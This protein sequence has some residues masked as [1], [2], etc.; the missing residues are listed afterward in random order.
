[1]SL[2][3]QRQYLKDNL[4]IVLIT[5]NRKNKLKNMVNGIFEENSPIKDCSITFLDNHSDDGT[6]EY[7]Q[8]LANK[9][10]N[11]IHIRHKYNIGGNA[12]IVRAM[13][14]VDTNKKYFW[15]LCD[16]DMLDWTHW[17]YH[18]T[19]LEEE[20]NDIIE[21]FYNF[22]V[23]TGSVYEEQI[24]SFTINATFVP[25]CI[26]KTRWL[27]EKNIFLNAYVNIHAMFP[28]AALFMHIVNNKGKI[29]RC[30]V[31][32]QI[33]YMLPYPNYKEDYHRGVNTT[34]KLHPH[35]QTINWQVGFS[36]S[37]GML[38]N[39]IIKK[40][41]VEYMYSF[42]GRTLEQFYSWY[43]PYALEYQQWY[44]LAN[45]YTS[46][47]EVQKNKI[48]ELL[49]MIHHS[50]VVIKK[51][52]L[53]DEFSFASSPSGLM[54]KLIILYVALLNIFIKTILRKK[55]RIYVH[56]K[57]YGLRL[58]IKILFKRT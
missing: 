22:L 27:L 7:L 36:L 58:A 23:P 19:L 37:L 3:K 26:Y 20:N 31:D 56:G 17:D 49:Y 45:L 30:T 10:S 1:M 46:A 47:D 55:Y 12:N 15:M 50:K 38:E 33:I 52:K 5:Y 25:S 13:E 51:Q 34:S 40:Y 53:L 48:Y 32:K 4:S 24:A 6:S 57:D 16:D 28:H 9:Q 41:C 29:S 11:V 21:L 42:Y 8:E 18:H 14:T 54:D 43:I 44:N 35:L 39:P 2:I